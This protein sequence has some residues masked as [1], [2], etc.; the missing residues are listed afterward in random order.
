LSQFSDYTNDEQEE[1]TIGNWL[2]HDL[3][4]ASHALGEDVV[5]AIAEVMDYE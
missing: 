4:G 1:K 2:E 3:E 5:G